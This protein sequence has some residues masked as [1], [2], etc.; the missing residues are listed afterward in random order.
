MPTETI[1]PEQYQATN[2]ELLRKVIE[3]QCNGGYKRFSMRTF[4][5]LREDGRLI[6]VRSAACHAL[7]ILLDTEGLRATSIAGNLYPVSDQILF[8][9]HSGK[10]NNLRA[11]LETAVSFLPTHD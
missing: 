1:T 4:T 3:A 5:C 7:E 9:W 8:A 2:E 11:A 6:N 10:G